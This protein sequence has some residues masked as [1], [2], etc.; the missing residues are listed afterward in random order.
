MEI[1]ATGIRATLFHLGQSLE[2][3]FRSLPLSEVKD[4]FVEVSVFL[5]PKLSIRRHAK[6][7]G[8]AEEIK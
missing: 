1:W 7:P 6:V 2:L 5:C 4:N 8:G 3:A